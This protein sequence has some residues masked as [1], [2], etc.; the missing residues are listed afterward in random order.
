LSEMDARNSDSLL[1][2]AAGWYARLAAPDCSPA[3]RTQFDLWRASSP[4]HIEACARVQGA[5][6]AVER[7]VARDPRLRAISDEAYA[8]A[9][10][11]TDPYSQKQRR[12][13]LPAALAA[14]LVI[15]LVGLKFGSRLIRQPLHPVVYENSS[16]GKITLEDGSIVYMDVNSRISVLMST[17]RR[18][19][20]LL[21]GRALFEVTHDASRPFSVIAGNARTTDLGTRFQVD[22]THEGVVV[23]LAEGAV[24]V[25]ST[26][27]AQHWQEHLSPGEQLAMSSNTSSPRKQ[28][29]D[30]LAATSWSRGRLVFRA[31]PLTLA[32]EEVNHYAAKKLRIADPSLTGLSVSGNF[33]AGDSELAAS[34]F[35]AV[36]P[37]RVVDGGTEIILVP[38]R[39]DSSP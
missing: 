4:S 3:E 26:L 22:R 9:R 31:T 21:A 23:T 38:G 13:A 15:A 24:V 33:V 20:E 11:G 1:E 5:A 16:V 2:E 29:V 12:W 34:A 6:D 36:L 28:V 25:D 35:A 14:S 32:V 17:K 39:A 37:I 30:P 27:A 19:V 18:Q 7:L 8:M 10:A